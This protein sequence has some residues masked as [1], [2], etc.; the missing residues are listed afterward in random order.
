MG[1]QATKPEI[2]EFNHDRLARAA[3]Q[4][5]CGEIVSVTIVNHKVDGPQAYSDRDDIYVRVN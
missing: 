1:G 5:K 2:E 3:M 4:A